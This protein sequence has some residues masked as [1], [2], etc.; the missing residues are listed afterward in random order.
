M[1][2]R[3]ILSFPANSEVFKK[4]QLFLK[5]ERSIKNFSNYNTNKMGLTY[6]TDAT[7][8]SNTDCHYSLTK[9]FGQ[10]IPSSELCMLFYFFLSINLKIIQCKFIIIKKKKIFSLFE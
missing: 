10:R 6:G 1:I 8:S 3:N 7:R 4:T 2:V 9:G 5:F